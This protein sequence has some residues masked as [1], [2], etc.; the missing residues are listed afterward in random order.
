[1]SLNKNEEIK[2]FIINTLHSEATLYT[3][4]GAYTKEKR[5]EIVT[6]VDKRE[7]QLLMDFIINNDPSAFVTVYNVSNIRY[8]PK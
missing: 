2:D 5:E 6:I 7:Y 8:V 4:T 3:S 1:M